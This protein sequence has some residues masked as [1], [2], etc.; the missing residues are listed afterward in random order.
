[1]KLRMYQEEAAA[2]IC[3]AMRTSHKLKV[4]ISIGLGRFAI[5]ASVLHSCVNENLKVLVLTPNRRTCYQLRDLFLESGHENDTGIAL[6]IKEYA[7]HHILITTYEDLKESEAFKANHF[8]IVICDGVHFLDGEI[9]ERKFNEKDTCFI[10]FTSQVNI[11]SHGWFYDA[12]CIFRY[13]IQDAI[14][15]GYVIKGYEFETIVFNLF[16]EQGY[17]V[18]VVTESRNIGY[19]LRADKGEIRYAI[20]AKLWDSASISDSVLRK[21]AKQ[22]I[23]AAKQENRIPMLVIANPSPQKIKERLSEHKDLVIIDIQNLLFMVQGNLK[24]EESLIAILGYS[25]GDLSPIK[26]EIE[27]NDV[28]IEELNIYHLI[29]TVKHWEVK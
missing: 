14:Q 12:K 28:K 21:T 16:K 19:D 24:I 5:I 9:I 20:E 10:G 15:D 23:D 17:S 22:L 1:M 4:Q 26:P 18:E 2:Q 3:E 13:T 6:Y 29:D 25:L 7:E 27:W 11:N 8:N